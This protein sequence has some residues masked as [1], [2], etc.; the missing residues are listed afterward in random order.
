[1]RVVQ[2][3]AEVVGSN[4]H[5]YVVVITAGMLMVAAFLMTAAKINVT[6]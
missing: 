4:M 3:C 2:W 5:L 6:V 1:M